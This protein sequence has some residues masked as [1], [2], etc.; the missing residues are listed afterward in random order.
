MNTEGLNPSALAEPLKEATETP[1]A[2]PAPEAPVVE[3]VPVA[4]AP[5]PSM[6][7]GSSTSRIFQSVFTGFPRMR[8]AAR[9]S[10][11]R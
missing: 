2:P 3:A 5:A 9:Y 8:F 11:L 10:F 1:V 4:P 6:A 7:P